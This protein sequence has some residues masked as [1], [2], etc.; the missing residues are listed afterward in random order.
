MSIR[1]DGQVAV[2]TGAGQGLGRSHALAL[3]ARG[4]RVLVNDLGENEVVREILDAGGDAMASSAN[5][6][7]QEQVL[8]MAQQVMDA[9]GRVDIL[10]NN[11]GILRDKSFLKMSMEDFR[12]VVDVHLI[13]SANCTHAVWE[14]MRQ[15]NYGRI[16]FTS[17][18]SGLFRKLWASQLRR[19]KNGH[20]GIDEHAAPGGRQ[21]QHSC[22]LPGACGRHR[23]DRGLAARA[24]FQV[25]DTRFGQPWRRLPVQ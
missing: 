20:G 24:R 5:V 2:V 25:A 13:G 14:I 10:V 12:Q 8:A 4:A 1:L 22:Q 21:V 9:W 18:S 3:A 19:R 15:Q 23:H 17:S 6:A 11:A 16:V 7:D